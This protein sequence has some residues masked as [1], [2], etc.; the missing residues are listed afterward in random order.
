VLRT[1][2]RFNGEGPAGLLDRKTDGP[3]SKL[4]PAQKAELAVLVVKPVPIA[5]RTAWCAG[6]GST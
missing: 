4:T 3:P 5:R 1:V 2:H 6:A